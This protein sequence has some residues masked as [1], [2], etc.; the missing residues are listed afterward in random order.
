[1]SKQRPKENLLVEVY[2]EDNKTVCGDTR[3]NS[4]FQKSLQIVMGKKFNF[5][6]AYYPQTG[7]FE[8]TIYTLEN[9]LKACVLDLGESQETYLPL[10]EFAYNN[11][12][13]ATIKMTPYEALQRKKIQ[14][15]SSMG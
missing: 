14:I 7:Q 5:S 8:K 13:Q 10:V 6:T 15:T 4:K 3:F 2:V 11:G 1:M 9:M 12:Y